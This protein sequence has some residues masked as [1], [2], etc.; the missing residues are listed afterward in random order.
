M[1]L[2][3]G[4]YIGSGEKNLYTKIVGIGDPAVVIETGLG[5][6]SVEWNDIQAEL[7]NHTTVISYDRAGYAESP[8]GPLP[9]VSGQICDELY[10]ML[11]NSGIPGPYILVGSSIGGLYMQHFS[12]M[13]P[14]AVAGLVLI[15]SMSPKQME[16]ESIDSPNFKDRVSLNSR[17]RNIKKFTEM[18]KDEFKAHIGPLLEGLY[19]G[20]PE[21]MQEAFALYQSDQNFYNTIVDEY[22]SLEES[23]KLTNQINVF[24]NIPVKVLCRDYEV[25]T[26]LAKQIGIPEEEARMIEEK[27]LEYSKELLKLSTESELIIA[28]GSAQSIHLSRPDIII[29]QILDM[30]NKVKEI[31]NL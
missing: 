1:E 26:Q 21:E 31:E 16:F 27:W 28:K 4:H 7:S 13:F 11:M 3:D 30:V 17:M 6:L 12:K 9:R 20:F 19:K 8:K 2:I 24:T 22:E 18:E 23:C 15:D 14:D 10:N 5:G 29:S 25:M